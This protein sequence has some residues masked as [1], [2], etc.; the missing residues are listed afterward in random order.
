MP[1]GSMNS[2]LRISPGCTAKTL[3]GLALR[4]RFLVVID[5]LDVISIPFPPHE[6]DTILIVDANAVLP[7]SIS[8]KCFQMVSRRHS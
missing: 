3:R 8:A 1:M 4:R 7:R 2:V 5:D 6:A